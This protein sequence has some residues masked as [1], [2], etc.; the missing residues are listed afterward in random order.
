[1]A[2]AAA[3]IPYTL[4]DAGVQFHQKD[5]ERLAEL[6]NILIEDDA[7]RQRIIVAQTERA[8]EYLAP[9]VHRQFIAYLE[10]NLA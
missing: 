6:V 3:A 10:R 4:G 9:Q 7:L 2:F 8:N 1:L 5:F